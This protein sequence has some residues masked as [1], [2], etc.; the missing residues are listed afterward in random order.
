MP[1]TTQW[2]TVV[3]YHA[4]LPAIAMRATNAI[5]ITKAYT[6]QGKLNDLSSFVRISSKFSIT[7]VF[8]FV[9]FLALFREVKIGKTA[10]TFA[11]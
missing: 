8:K 9:L 1:L 6:H 11:F 2:R 5:G 10:A 4:T 7:F 3:V